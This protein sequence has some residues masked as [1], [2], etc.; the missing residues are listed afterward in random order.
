MRR[1]FGFLILF[2]FFALF[3]TKETLALNP[4]VQ[5]KIFMPMVI[6]MTPKSILSPVWEAMAEPYVRQETPLTTKQFS[7]LTIRVYFPTK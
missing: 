1:V 2:F 7:W 4:P 6:P 3:F 5:P